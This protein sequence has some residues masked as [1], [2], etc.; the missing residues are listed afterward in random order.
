[1]PALQ[2][3]SPDIMYPILTVKPTAF[4]TLRYKSLYPKEY[5]VFKTGKG[6]PVFE[7]EVIQN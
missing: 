7:S 4:T 2:N 3:F 6:L 1:M 5:F